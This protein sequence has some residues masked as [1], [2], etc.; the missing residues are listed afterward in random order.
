MLSHLFYKLILVIPETFRKK[1]VGI[2]LD[3]LFR[4]FEPICFRVENVHAKNFDRLNWK[5]PE[6][7][8]YLVLHL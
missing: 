4:R 8:S 3:S 5:E 2:T 7:T 1:A 6:R